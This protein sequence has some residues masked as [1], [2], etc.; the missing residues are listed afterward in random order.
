MLLSPPAHHYIYYL[1][2]QRALFHQHSHLNPIM[3]VMTPVIGF[4]VVF[5]TVQSHALNS[6]F[7]SSAWFLNKPPV[8]ETLA[9]VSL[10]GIR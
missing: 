1:V 8:T 3:V 6:I 5:I 7:T 2:F 4:S 10:I 9:M